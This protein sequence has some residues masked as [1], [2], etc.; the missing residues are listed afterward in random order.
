VLASAPSIADAERP[1]PPEPLSRITLP[2]LL[3]VAEVTRRLD[4]AV[5][6]AFDV[7]RHRETCIEA[8]WA[9][10]GP[11][12]AKISPS[13]S[14]EV[15]GKVRRTGP[16]TFRG[17]G[18]S[19]FTLSI[20]VR[21][22]VTVWGTG[23]IGKHLR[24]TVEAAAIVTSEIT[25]PITPDE[26]AH[27]VKATTTTAWTERPAFQLFNT[28]DVRTPS[29]VEPALADLDR[30]VADAASDLD[31]RAW[32]A[33]AVATAPSCSSRRRF[34]AH[35]ARRRSTYRPETYR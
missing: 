26:W 2:V 15:R 34:R 28:F 14:C 27:S 16:A 25:L 11:L 32:S 12:K 13:V 20:P 21:G 17:G 18:G 30:Q 22:S 8:E 1:E 6:S 24:P 10:I 23:E 33:A 35:L 4:E 19:A 3:S 5:P 7:P 9:V 31:L 29:K